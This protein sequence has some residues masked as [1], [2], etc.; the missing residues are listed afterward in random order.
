VTTPLPEV[1]DKYWRTWTHEPTWAA[2]R[3]DDESG[4]TLVT[5]DELSS[6]DNM[7]PGNVFEWCWEHST[8]TGI[9]RDVLLM[10]AFTA[11]SDNLSDIIYVK[12]IAEAVG[13][14]DEE[15]YGVMVALYTLERIGDMRKFQGYPRPCYGFPAYETWL[16]EHSGVSS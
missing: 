1:T 12:E 15:S 4:T 16:K 9:A 14:V 2:Y 13:D 5:P 7:P 10:Y 6:L 11:D 8:A 3:H